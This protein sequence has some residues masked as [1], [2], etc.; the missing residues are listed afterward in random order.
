MFNLIYFM[1]LWD[2]F[3]THSLIHMMRIIFFLYILLFYL[4]IEC[5]QFVMF[6]YIILYLYLHDSHFQSIIV[7]LI[8]NLFL[9]LSSKIKSIPKLQFFRWYNENKY[10]KK[11]FLV[12]N[13]LP[14]ICWIVYQWKIIGLLLLSISV[15]NK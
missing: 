2:F 15:N 3:I 8:I 6:E 1:F 9:S 12:I 7:V 11:Y 14:L 5:L 13:F 10:A 4:F